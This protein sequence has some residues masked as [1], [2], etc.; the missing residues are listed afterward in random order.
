MYCLA[1]NVA[2]T[3]VVGTHKKCLAKAVL[4]SIHYV[5]SWSNK[6]TNKFLFGKKRHYLATAKLLY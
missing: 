3:Y 5:F 1:L 2:K 6:V 4:M